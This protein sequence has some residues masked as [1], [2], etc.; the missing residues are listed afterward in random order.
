MLYYTQWSYHYSKILCAF[1]SNHSDAAPKNALYVVFIGDVDAGFT[2]TTDTC[3]STV[4][5]NE[6]CN[7]GANCGR[8]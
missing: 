7:Y 2:N 3:F 1:L 6:G 8:A 5:L 4:T